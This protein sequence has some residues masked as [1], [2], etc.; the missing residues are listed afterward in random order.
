MP[1]KRLLSAYLDYHILDLLAGPQPDDERI[2]PDWSAARAIWQRYKDDRIQL[3]TSVEEMELDFV[4]H[5]NRGGMCVTD[6]FQITDN[7]DYFE[8]WELADRND[9][10]RWRAIVDLY[11]QLEVVNEHSDTGGKGQIS[12]LH[13]HIDRVLRGEEGQGEGDRI[14][15]T[16]GRI[17]DTGVRGQREIEQLILRDCAAILH[18]FYD[19]V[20]WADLKHLD[21][22]LNWRVLKEVLP[23]HERSAALNG[24]QAG[25]NKN[26]LGLLNRLIGISKK[27]CPKLPMKE[28]HI[29]F[30]LDIVT[31]KYCQ[32]NI[33][34]HVCHIACSM[35]GDINYYLTIDDELA[36]RF[37]AGKHR[38]RDMTGSGE[39]SLEVLRPVELERKLSGE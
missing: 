36:K 14:Q 25:F 33:D 5:M 31:K 10:S 6:T 39:I 37:V 18:E 29:D 19:V 21:Y 13:E 9:T 23:R 22:D 8:R 3:V 27:S 35:R 12:K 4:I 2:A 30:L 32:E 16:G 1:Q 17:Q 20:K 38:L 11:D 26:L 15:D 34:R 7:I 28:S 24:E